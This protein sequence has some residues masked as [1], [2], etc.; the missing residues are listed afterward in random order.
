MALDTKDDS[1][2][3]RRDDR[4]NCTQSN[5]SFDHFGPLFPFPR[6]SLFPHKNVCVCVCVLS[7]YDVMRMFQVHKYKYKYNTD[8][9]FDMTETPQGPADGLY[10]DTHT[11]THTHIGGV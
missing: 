7:I 10:N 8:T 6:S 2:Y 9:I 5:P 1:S 4:E 11:R 3:L